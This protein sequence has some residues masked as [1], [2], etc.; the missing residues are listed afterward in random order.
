MALS[1]A[2]E[3]HNDD[4]ARRHGSRSRQPRGCLYA[5]QLLPA[6]RR[7]APKEHAA[8]ARRADI[9]MHIAESVMAATTRACL[10]PMDSPLPLSPKT[11]CKQ[12]FWKISE[13]RPP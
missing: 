3:L 12:R 4:R 5:V 13:W 1:M 6:N 10:L 9:E 7:S 11:S 2:P 8:P